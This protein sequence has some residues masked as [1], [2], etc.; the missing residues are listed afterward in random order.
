MNHKTFQFFLYLFTLVQ[1]SNSIAT[2]LNLEQ[3]NL[4]RPLLAHKTFESPIPFNNVFK[5]QVDHPYIQSTDNWGLKVNHV[6]HRYALSAPKKYSPSER[7][8]YFHWRHFTSTD[9]GKTWKDLGIALQADHDHA[10]ALWSGNVIYTKEKLFL[11]AYT[12]LSNQAKY[13]QKIG[14]A[15]SRNGH[16]FKYLSPENL[17]DVQ[18]YRPSFERLGYYVDFENLGNGAELDQNIMAFRDPFLFYN[19]NGELE[20]LIAMKAKRNG[21]VVSCLGRAK[22]KINTQGNFEG[23]AFEKPIFLPDS[24]QFKQVELPNFFTVDKKQ[25]LVVS[26]TNRISQSQPARGGT[27]GLCR[28]R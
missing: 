5:A 16:D 17:I 27:C 11:A 23:L 1:T 24:E 21:K 9:N 14:L 28:S 6:I 8:F 10:K 7:D 19:K 18:D 4:C 26:T 13:Y 15:I 2:T 22:L 3:F 25:Y 12:E 20:I